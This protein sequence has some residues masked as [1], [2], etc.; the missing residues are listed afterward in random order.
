MSENHLIMF[1]RHTLK[2]SLSWGV[3][4]LITKIPSELGTLF[5]Q[6]VRC[7]RKVK[8]LNDGNLNPSV[9]NL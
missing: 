1:I 8:F 7:F 5:N 4:N 9:F 3:F 2:Y 6:V